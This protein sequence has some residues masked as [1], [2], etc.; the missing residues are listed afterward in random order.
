MD[1]QQY[2]AVARL[3]RVRNAIDLELAQ[4]IERPVTT[5]HLGEWIAAKVFGIALH[6]RASHKG[7][8]GTFTTGPLAGR[9][10]NIKWYTKRE[11]SLDMSS[12]ARPDYYLVMTGPFSNLA[13]SRGSARPLCVEEVYLFDAEALVRALTE[14]GASVG[15]ASSVRVKE[16][17]DAQVY[18][19]S[20]D[21]FPLSDEQRA[22]LSLLKS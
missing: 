4:L 7:S 2:E 12:S 15:Y 3:L 13:T 22:A 20:V 16:W 18:P 5:G 6:E 9:S 19:T 17:S 10:V 1:D 21:F 14:R 11:N 8:D